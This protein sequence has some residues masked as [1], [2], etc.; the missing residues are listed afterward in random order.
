M[1]LHKMVY[2]A[3]FTFPTSANDKFVSEYKSFN[4]ID[5]LIEGSLKANYTNL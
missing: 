2:D 1:W 4:Y 3:L 5:P